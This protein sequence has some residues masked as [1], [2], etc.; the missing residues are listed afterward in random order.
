MYFQSQACKSILE[1]PRTEFPRL[2]SCVCLH[3]MGKWRTIFSS[4]CPRC[5]A[6]FSQR[7]K[8]TGIHPWPSRGSPVTVMSIHCLLDLKRQDPVS[9]NISRFRTKRP[10]PTSCPGSCVQ[11]QLGGCSHVVPSKVRYAVIYHNGGIYMDTDF[12]VQEAGM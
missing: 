5:G 1:I 12:L 3:V 9:R 6:Y 10:D 11:W 7:E 2:S 8:H 4:V